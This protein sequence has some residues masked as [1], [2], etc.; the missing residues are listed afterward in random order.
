M[1][2]FISVS[3]NGYTGSASTASASKPHATTRAQQHGEGRLARTVKENLL[4]SVSPA[5][6]WNTSQANPLQVPG[7]KLEHKSLDWGGSFPGSHDFYR[8]REHP[9]Q[10]IYI[11]KPKV[12]T[13]KPR[14]KRVHSGGMDRGSAKRSRTSMA[15]SQADA[16]SYIVIP[17][18]DSEEDA[19]SRATR[20]S[21]FIR[22][23]QATATPRPEGG[24]TYRY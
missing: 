11:L 1:T 15:A 16:S 23:G 9:D 6:K 13:K 17:S 10:D 21:P 18:S 7:T 24:V 19:D 5:I 22:A 3:S 14:H 8:T 4:Q 2:E 12:G 20:G